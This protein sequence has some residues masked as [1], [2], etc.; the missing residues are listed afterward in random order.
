MSCLYF[1]PIK[2]LDRKGNNISYEGINGIFGWTLEEDTTIEGDLVLIDDTLDLNG[3]KLNITGNLIQYSGIVYV[4]GGELVVD[5]DYRI[6]KEEVVDGNKQY[7]TGSGMLKMTNQNDHVLVKGSFIDQSFTDFSGLL[8]EGILE[9]KG[10]FYQI[11]GSNNNFRATGN[12]TVLFSGEGKQTVKFTSSWS[13]QSGFCNLEIQNSSEEGVVFDATSSYPLA[14]G[15]V[16]DNGNKVT[17][18]L[19]IIGSTSFEDK[20]Y[21]SDLVVVENVELRN[22]IE[23]DGNFTVGEQY[24]LYLYSKLTVGGDLRINTRYTYTYGNIYTK[25]NMYIGGRQGNYMYFYLNDGSIKVDGDLNISK[26]R[27][28]RVSHNNSNKDLPVTVK[29]NMSIAD[30]CYYIFP[31]GSLTLGGNLSGNGY[32]QL[33]GTHKTILN[34][35]DLQII[36]MTESSYFANLEIQNYSKAG[37]SFNRMIKYDSF[38]RNGCRVSFGENSYE[39]GWT[40]AENEVYDAN[41]YLWDDTLDLNGNTLTINGDFIAMGGK[42]NFN[43]GKLIVNGNMRVQSVD[44]ES[45][46]N[47]T[48]GAGSAS[49]TMNNPSDYL[50]VNGSLYYYPKTSASVFS[51]GTVEIKGDF[52]QYGSNPYKGTANNT[53]KFTGGSKQTI[54]EDATSVFANFVNENAEELLMKSSVNVTGSFT[55]S[56]ENINGSGTVIV[57]NPSVISNGICSGNLQV[58]GGSNL[59]QDLSVEG[60]LTVDSTMHANGKNISAKNLV[61][62][63]ALYVDK[64]QITV[65]NNI[66]VERYGY[67]IMINDDDYVLANGNFTFNSYYNHSTYLTAG[68]LELRGDFTQN[69]SQNFIASGSHTTIFSRKKSTTGREYVQT[70]T[71]NS[72]AGTT[73]F[74]KIV[75]KKK[76]KE[77]HFLQPIASI[78]NEVV[79]AIEDD[80]APSAVAYI[81]DSEVTEKSV[82]IGF[83]GAED[84]NGILGYEVYR[85]GKLLGVT[86]NTIY[87]DNSVDSDTQYTYTVF[88]FDNERNKASSSPT[89]NVRT[90]KDS[91]APSIP[92]NIGLKTR[93]GSSITIEWSPS[94]DNVKV[95][96]Y[97]VYANGELLAENVKETTYKAANLEKTHAYKFTVEAV[98]KAGNISDRSAELEAEV[99]MPKILSVTPDDN[100]SIGGE[101]IVLNIYFEN[102]GNST[103][104]KVAIQIKN[105][106]DE[107]ETIVNRLSQKVA[108]Y[109]RLYATYTWD[110]SE[111]TGEDSYDIRY[112]LTDADGNEDT[113]EVTYIIDK[114]GPEV[115]GNF[116]A[117]ANNGNVNISFDASIS[118]DCAGYEI[119]RATYGEDKLLCT[120]KGR[121]ETIYVDKDVNIGDTYEYAVYAFDNFGNKSVVSE[122][123]TVQIEADKVAPEIQDF[124]PRAGRVNANAKFEISARDNKSVAAIGLQYKAVDATDWIDVEEKNA[125]NDKAT[126]TFDTTALADGE[127]FFNAYAIDASGNRSTELFTRRYEV[128]NTGIAK[129]VITNVSSGSSFA[130]IEWEDVTEEDFGYFAVEQL[131][132]GKYELVG[133]ESEILGYYVKNLDPDTNYTFRVVGYDDLGNRGIESDEVSITTTEDNNGPTISAVYPESSCYS[134]VI[135]LA[136]EAKDDNELDYAVFSYT[137][138]GKEFIE[139]EKVDAGDG[140][141][142]MRFTKDFDISQI[143]ECDISVKFE[144]YDVAGNKN[145]LASDGTD[146]IVDYRIDRTAPSKVS[147]LKCKANEGYVEI[148][149]DAPG[150][151]GQDVKGFKIWRADNANGIYNLIKDDCNTLNYYDT[152]V[153]VGSMYLYKVAA[154][155]LAGNVGELS[156]EIIVTVIKDNDAPMIYGI[157]PNTN[158]KIC[159]NQTFS[160]TAI[161]NAAVASVRL[162]YTQEGERNY[163]RTIGKSSEN[164]NYV[165]SKITWDTEKIEEG[166]Y[167]IR[168]IATDSFGNESEACLFTYVLDKT[169]L[170]VTDI[171]TSTGHFEIEVEATLEDDSDYSYMEV[172]RREV[173]GE[174]KVIGKTEELKYVDS[175]IKANKNYFYKV[176]VYDEAGNVSL[177]EEVGGYADDTDVIAPVAV[178]PENYVG[179]VGMELGLDGLASTDNVRITEYKWDMGN[180]DV[181][182]GATPRYTYNKAGDYTVTLTVKDAAGNQSSVATTARIYEKTGKGKTKVQIVDEGG[183][184]IPY[185]LVYLKL[186]ENNGLPLKAD[187]FGYV[188]IVQDVGV[189]RIAA[190]KQDYLP[191]EME[192]MISEYEV[193]EYKLRLVKNALIVGKLTVHRMSLE[194]MQEAGVIFGGANDHHYTFTIELVYQQVPYELT[195]GYGGFGGGG[196][197][198]IGGVGG[199]GG[200]GTPSGPSSKRK[201]PEAQVVEVVEEK[202]ILVTVS[203]TDSISWLKDMFQVDLMVINM[204]DYQFAIEN[205]TARIDYPDGVSLADLYKGQSKTQSMGTIHGQETKTASWVLRGDKSGEYEVS[206]D[207]N[208]ILMPF[209]APV[210]AHFV[211]DS[212]I[213][214]R[215]GEG[216]HITIMPE[217]TVDCGGTLYIQYAIENNSGS[218]CFR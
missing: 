99:K 116:K 139:I 138:D 5:G 93:T 194:E 180:G 166:E 51:E 68:V 160:V 151:E 206:A 153:K 37:V 18:A 179:I 82:S 38:V 176:R 207:F 171:S 199:S 217:S 188:E 56:T 45:E 154:V 60:N 88:A 84:N 156:D 90:K 52:T 65:S 26:Q 129:I 22:E 35:E 28:T 43:G 145:V 155:D 202:P 141:K 169:P 94:T 177:S 6:Q 140:K 193:K 167:Q 13:D 137:T 53:V 115:P 81:V 210:S 3:H 191:S 9:I 111:L 39:L 110:V 164:S 181:I 33:S 127:Y 74:N 163:W 118:A 174:F 70:I 190:Y 58:T 96:G 178:L 62:N 46:G 61:L 187:K 72:Y 2:T 198:G 102:V 49:L 76:E 165:I 78:S 50:L 149:W 152:S 79:Y 14:R 1:Y 203:K 182:K 73:R 183:M 59:Q 186:D 132:N 44:S 126:F 200:G 64:S 10:D 157:Y 12:H 192:I 197:G 89:L 92:Q 185:A 24:S 55:D 29:G 19:A 148:A 87:V 130:R 122:R 40:L 23:T 20:H 71:F 131:I 21:C 184:G 32:L 209:E 108:S 67:L 124:S 204:A 77:Y 134:N 107:W 119:R 47:V 42:V 147:N 54:T 161:D 103:G 100:Q 120:L 189:G 75:L 101:S 121:Y 117:V 85:D 214:V 175:D 143:E 216:I 30:G 91:E 15:K 212:S 104:N 128:D 158:S 57:S 69:N 195:V 159:A 86:S 205:S 7:I 34:G 144:V 172:L 133:K 162:E 125:A 63:A 146:L 168:A 105:D 114:E 170:K 11:S 48:Y 95:A 218:G 142:E 123:V 201:E 97:N 36:E 135:K 16:K 98:D 83:G 150:E 17:G 208:G 215:T 8:T 113:K 31:K 213:T 173:G 109:G 106:N 41:F 66:T 112:V 211:A 136:I 196:G 27:E 80:E 25:G 4:H